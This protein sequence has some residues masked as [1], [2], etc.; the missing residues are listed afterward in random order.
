M[1]KFNLFTTPVIT[2]KVDWS[3]TKGVF[4]KPVLQIPKAIEVPDTTINDD[5]P[6]AVEVQDWVIVDKDNK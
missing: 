6:D 5:V 1:D 4:P 3:D 2:V